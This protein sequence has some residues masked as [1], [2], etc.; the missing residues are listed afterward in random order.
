M[1]KVFKIAGLK[2]I[3]I[4]NHNHN[5]FRKSQNGF[6]K[7]INVS[8]SSLPAPIY[9]VKNSNALKNALPIVAFIGSAMSALGYF[10]GGA[11]LFYDL[12]YEKKLKK[13]PIVPP[14]ALTNYRHFYT[15]K[16]PET[17]EGVK[18]ITTST[19]IGKICMDFTKVGMMASGIAGV[20]C[21][22]GEGLPIMAIGEA[23]NLGAANIIE[24]PIGT[25][26]FGIGIASIFSALALDN[27][28][29]LKL[30]PLH[31]MAESSISKKLKMIGKN[32][33][34][35]GKEILTSVKQIG[36]NLFKPSF[37]KD[38]F[39]SGTPKTIV[40]EE[41]INKDGIGNISK[42]LR[43]NK[44]YLMHAASF[45]LGI[46]GVSLIISSLLKA[47]KAQK[48]SLR[49]EEG[50][51]LF[52][53]FGMTRY[54]IDKLSTGGKAAGIPFAVGGVI[55]AISQFMQIDNKDGRAMQWLGISLVFL[56]F[57]VDRGK[58]L[59]KALA[60]SKART[61]LTDIVRQWKFDLSELFKNDPKELKKL[62]NEIKNGKPV[63][64]QKFIEFENNFNKT[65]EGEFKNTNQAKSLLEAN[66][67]KETSDKFIVQEIAD[68]EKTKEILTICTEKMFGSKNPAPIN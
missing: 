37:V 27:T 62:L 52:D 68:C 61:E 42:L 15:P 26:I 57:S 67:G 3:N 18:T 35:T 13:K 40:F 4:S 51:F 49:A 30:N 17:D 33:I 24:T 64:N 66:L 45:T 44:N 46:G 32:I 36:Q 29:E 63:S 65:F 34:S 43:H 14:P 48:A 10:V 50:G 22:L 9:A 11:G 6:K 58:F 38:N 23:T 21:G 19:K 2:L 12:S 5:S 39:L 25:G 16:K 31:L 41:R 53:N 1:M 54:G 47:K 56:G 7:D 60:N 20:A 8:F 59:K 55:N 28:P